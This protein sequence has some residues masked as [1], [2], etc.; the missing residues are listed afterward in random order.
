MESILGSGTVF[1]YVTVE[2][3]HAI[4]TFRKKAIF[5]KVHNFTH[6]KFDNVFIS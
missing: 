4:E 3:K 5:V 6:L 1:M 2:W